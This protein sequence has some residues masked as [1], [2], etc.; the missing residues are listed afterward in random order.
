M[1]KEWQVEDINVKKNIDV[2]FYIVNAIASPSSLLSWTLT[3]PLK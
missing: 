3:R 2:R 1:F